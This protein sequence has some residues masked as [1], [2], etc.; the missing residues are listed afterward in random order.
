M[1]DPETTAGASSVPNSESG[2]RAEGIPATPSTLENQRLF[3]RSVQLAVRL[4]VLAWLLHQSYRAIQPL[5]EP[6]IW[7]GLIAIAT[8]PLHARF[9]KALGNRDG[10]AAT[11]FGLF[12]ALVFLV[13]LTLLTSSL[14]RGVRRLTTAYN[15]GTLALPKPPA[16]IAELPLVGQTLAST[17]HQAAQNPEAA[18]E[19]YKPQLDRLRDGVTDGVAAA[20]VQ[21]L[22]LLLAI[23]IAVFILAK[24][25]GAIRAVRSVMNKLAP[26]RGAAIQALC[27]QTIRSVAQGIVGIAFIQA[28]LAGVGFVVFGM[29]A[30]GIFAFLILVLAICQL[31]PAIVLLPLSVY[32]FSK[33]DTVMATIFLVWNIFV[34]LIDNVL[35]PLLLGRGVDV[36]MLVILVGAIGG[37]IARGIMGLFLGPVIL[38]VTYTLLVEWFSADNATT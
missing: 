29:P 10:L 30:P 24:T 22:G 32:A 4:G 12:I 15:E 21:L 3:E 31:P 8:R 35:R 26:T 11:L 5:L 36:P 34:S 6:L 13:P 9:S 1:T 14:V 2:S 19:K 33:G 18:L 25:E 17:W 28:A 23:G 37:L 7:G 27:G 16:D 38:A 20:G